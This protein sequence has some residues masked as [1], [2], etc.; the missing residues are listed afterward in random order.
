MPYLSWKGDNL[1]RGRLNCITH[2]GRCRTAIGSIVISE[3]LTMVFTLERELKL[4]T[5]TITESY[6]ESKQSQRQKGKSV[7]EDGTS[8]KGAVTWKRA[9]LI[10]GYAGILPFSPKCSSARTLGLIFNQFSENCKVTTS[11]SVCFHF[12]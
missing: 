5:V 11:S 9:A 8:G 1:R 6:T 2:P 10:L 4:I 3:F 12:T 7:H